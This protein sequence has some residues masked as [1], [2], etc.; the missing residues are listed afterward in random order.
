MLTFNSIKAF[1]FGGHDTTAST[2]AVTLLLLYKYLTQADDLL[3]RLIRTLPQSRHSRN[4]SPRAHGRVWPRSRHSPHYS[5]R[6]ASPRQPTPAHNSR[7][8]RDAPVIPA[9]RR[10]KIG[11]P[12]VRY[13]F[14]PHTMIAHFHF[15]FLPI[16]TRE[17]SLSPTNRFK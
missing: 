3:V 10:L 14:L 12:R 7:H 16:P 17:P 6:E 8:Q 13:P 11:R 15:A 1:I 5:P 9:S 4:G 2:I